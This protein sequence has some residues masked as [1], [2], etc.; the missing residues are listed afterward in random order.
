MLGRL[1]P[2]ERERVE[3]AIGADP[4]LEA[5]R[6]E[7]ARHLARYDALEAPPPPP[8]ARLAARLEERGQAARRAFPRLAWAG[9]AVA[10]LLLAALAL[11]VLAPVSS[12]AP[13]L[14]RGAGL[15]VTETGA[16]LAEEEP[17]EAWIGERVHVVLDGGAR[18][19]P[20]SDRR[21]R[22]LAGRAWFEVGPGPGP[23]EVATA[24]GS[25]RV[26]G[27][28]FEVAVDDASLFVA[29]AEGR[30]EV[31]GRGEVEGRVLEAGQVLV[32]GRRTASPHQAGA[33]FRHPTLALAAAGAPLAG[34][35]LTLRFTFGNPGRVPFVL[36][37]P[38]GVRAA[39]WLE[40]VDPSGGVHDLAV[41]GV[42]APDG[43][44]PAGR[45]LLLPGR[46][47]TSFTVRL[48]RPFPG[49]RI[50]WDRGAYRCR[51]LYRPEGQPSLVSD[52][53]LLEVR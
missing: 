7:V 34:E 19:A 38:D 13:T 26:V 39:L 44:L 30:V 23:F 12:H 22:L 51:A 4:A 16:W 18:L 25:V 31:A 42:D 50:G 29:V 40:I 24:L 28:T 37:G 20:E 9:A 5:R 11:H 33:F 53:L 14:L 49:D 47:E 17:A 35:P 15:R 27:T 48:A 8:F 52:A 6:E 1:D 3:R 43:P 36:A 45:P 10:A 2:A 46:D 21:V 41:P 32:N